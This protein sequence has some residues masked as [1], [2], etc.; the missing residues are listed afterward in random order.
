MPSKKLSS[1]NAFE[2]LINLNPRVDILPFLPASISLK[3]SLRKNHIKRVA[4]WLLGNQPDSIRA[5]LSGS[6]W[7]SAKSVIVLGNI[8]QIFLENIDE[9]PEYKI[10]A[11]RI[12]QVS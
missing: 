10:I 9:D 8:R 11:T 6:P 1:I 5:Q 3:E 4:I 12:E 7:E 2:E